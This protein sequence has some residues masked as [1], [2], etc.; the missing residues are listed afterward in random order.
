M[1]NRGLFKTAPVSTKSVGITAARPDSKA[2]R[3]SQAMKNLVRTG[4]IKSHVR[5]NA[6]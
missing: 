5:T 3:G 1:T 2:V 4:S 6:T